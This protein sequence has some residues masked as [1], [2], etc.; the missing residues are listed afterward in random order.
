MIGKKP[1]HPLYNRVAEIVA[2]KVAYGEIRH[3]EFKGIRNQS[4]VKAVLTRMGFEANCTNNPIV[5]SLAGTKRA[6]PKIDKKII[7]PKYK[8]KSTS[9]SQQI[10]DDLLEGKTIYVDDIPL[11]R[12]YVIKIV[13]DIRRLGIRVDM[14]RQ[15]YGVNT[16][17]SYK[18]AEK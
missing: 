7:M 11:C 1:T 8:R 4:S 3:S 16:G 12:K 6:A 10:R 14:N 18:V 9:L 15:G 13:N 2:Q 5:W 17:L